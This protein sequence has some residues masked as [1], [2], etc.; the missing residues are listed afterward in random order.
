[1]VNFNSIKSFVSKIGIKDFLFIAVIAFLVFK[2]QWC[3]PP[4]SSN[5]EIKKPVFEKLEQKVDEKGIT[6]SIINQ[7][8][9]T[10]KEMKIITDSLKK[11][12]KVSGVSQVTQTITNV[13]AELEAK[14]FYVDTV[15]HTINASYQDKDIYAEFNGNTVTKYGMFKFILTPD[16]M[17][18]VTTFKKKLFK[19]DIYSVDVSHTNGYFKTVEGLS[20]TYKNPKPII[21]IGPTVGVLYD[22]KFKPFV[23]VGATFNL[24]SIKSK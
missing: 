16:T 23:G 11:A 21:V 17:T 1:M 20:Y 15:D 24:I 9:Y 3:N 6:H 22:G 7:R 12:L 8:V 4:K 10:E 13:E 19:P 5:I 2:V 18:Y 14:T